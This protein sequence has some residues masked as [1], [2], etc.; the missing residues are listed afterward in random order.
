MKA[1]AWMR[2]NLTTQGYCLSDTQRRDLSL[3]LRFST[4]V[5]LS[6]VAVALVLQSPVMLFALSAIGVVAS[7]SATHPF[8]HLWNH[9][10]RHLV[11]GPA[12]PPNPPRRRDA[13]KVAT[14]W[15]AIVATLLAAGATTVALALGGLLVAACATVTA[16]NLCLPSEFFAWLD[17]R[18]AASKPI[19]T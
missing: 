2:S 4:G 12:L 1:S 16:T 6:L 7:F 5:C 11:R 15:L 10:V 18:R 19:T 13:F 17:R 14:A 9:G 8:D 3:G